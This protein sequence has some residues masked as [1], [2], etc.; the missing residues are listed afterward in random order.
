MIVNINGKYQEV[1]SIS[2]IP[3]PSISYEDLVEQLIRE[4]YSLSQEISIL[5]QKDN[6]P[7]AFNEYNAFCE[8]CKLKA[9][10][11]LGYIK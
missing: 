11:L 5:R 9:K 2:S 1:D 4:K 8:Q 7:E 3:L 10:Q 6:K